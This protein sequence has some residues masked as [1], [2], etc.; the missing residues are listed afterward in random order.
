MGGRIL[1]ILGGFSERV[2]DG[3]KRR[4]I[5][6]LRPSKQFTSRRARDRNTSERRGKGK[7]AATE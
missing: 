4:R 2:R 3:E 7:G 5:Y 1:A 6:V